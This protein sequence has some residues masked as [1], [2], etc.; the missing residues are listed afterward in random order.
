MISERIKDLTK[1]SSAIRAMFEEGARLMKEFGPE[2]VY[3][4]SLGNPSAQAPEA[5]HDTIKEVLD[6][7][8][9]LKLHGYMTNVGFEDVRLAVANHLN[10][11]YGTRFDA[12][13][14][15]MTVGAA[16]GLNVILQTLLNPEDEV[17]FLKPYFGEYRHYVTNYQGK[18][19]EV[20][21]VEDTFEPSLADLESKISPKTKAIIINNPNNPSGVVYSK[22]FL[23]KFLSLLVKKEEEFG[24]PIYLIADE[25]Y[26][27]LV[28]QD[29]EVPYLPCLY[30]NSIVVYSYSKS[31]SLPGERIG[32]LV[33]PDE[34]TD[35]SLI[36][37]GVGICTR[38]LGFVN[39][40]A[41]FQKVIAKNLK[42][43]SDM[44]SYINN[45]NT[46]YSELT[47]YG[48]D[49]VKPEGAFYLWI[50]SP[51]EDAEGFIQ[52]AKEYRILLVSGA[53]FGAPG[54]IRLAYCVP[55]ERVKNSLPFFK[56]LIQE[57][58]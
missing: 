2:N 35:A 15:A 58:K 40:P 32:Y 36:K 33:L 39:A 24:Q 12:T 49:V 16:G 44:S 28:Y 50:K 26:R 51:I 34:L 9:V 11:S 13:N 53:N 23:D 47:N 55:E 25:P 57:V 31:L 54:Y 48:Y 17:L 42:I 7:E 5:I 38:I 19:L 1:N 29:V 30:H 43:T 20:D 21:F 56:Q 46:L 4:F 10:E 41:L 45:R 52:K 8:N 6:T 37:Q 3:D 27:E 22:A 18:Y 14:I